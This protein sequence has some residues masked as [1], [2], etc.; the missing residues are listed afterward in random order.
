MC[1]N[2]FT[3]S[4]GVKLPVRTLRDGCVEVL[5]TNN[6]NSIIKHSRRRSHL[7]DAVED[8]IVMAYVMATVLE[9]LRVD[10][11]ATLNLNCVIHSSSTTYV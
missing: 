1:R 8:A 7:N 6:E 3:N 5:K 9:N 2:T 11:R 10:V 4:P